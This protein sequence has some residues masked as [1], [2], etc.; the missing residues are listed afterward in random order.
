MHN[1]DLYGAIMYIVYFITDIISR[2]TH[3]QVVSSLG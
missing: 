2:M 3:L 1:N